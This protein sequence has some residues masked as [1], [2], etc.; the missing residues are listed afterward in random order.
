MNI[1]GKTVKKN[2]AILVYN[3]FSNEPIDTNKYVM[4]FKDGNTY[5]AD[6]GNLYLVTKKEYYESRSMNGKTKFTT[7]TKKM[8]RGEYK[9]KGISMR[10]LCQKY[11][12]SL[13]TMQKILAVDAKR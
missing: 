9:D 8:I 5:N 11:N 2:R 7:D 12:C 1:D 3:A 4:R 10:T 6:Y 13:L